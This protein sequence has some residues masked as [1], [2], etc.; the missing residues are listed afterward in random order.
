MDL[1]VLKIIELNSVLNNLIEG[2]DDFLYSKKIN[3]TIKDKILI[4]LYEKPCSPYELIK[5]LSVAKSNL[6]LCAKSLVKQN[7]IVQQKDEIDKRNIL[8]SITEQGK[9]KGKEIILKINK[10]ISTKLEHK[11][12]VE[13]INK[14]I[15]GLLKLLS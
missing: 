15:D 1:D 6:A 11:N 7:L 3:L 8:Y 10:A 5:K 2:F 12:N 4:S 9:N 14:N 13:E